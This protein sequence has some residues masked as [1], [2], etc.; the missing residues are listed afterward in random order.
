MNIRMAET[1]EDIAACYPV[2]QELRP[3]V[4]ENEFVVRVRL[5][6]QS[7]YQLALVEDEGR[8]VAV[9]GFR[10]GENFAWG[11]FLYVDDLITAVN[12]RSRGYG[13]T[14]LSW[15]RHYATAN[16]CRHM[17]LDSG[18]QR[19]DAHRFYEREGMFKSGFHFM[20]D[21]E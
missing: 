7:G 6:E 15:L 14:L 3:H 10:T 4:A 13:A 20:Q 9:A 19:A 8:I 21:L 17:H 16:D 1:D 11:R 5:Q 12:R 2:M 18:L